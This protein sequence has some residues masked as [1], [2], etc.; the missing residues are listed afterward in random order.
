MPQVV[1][2]LSA[3]QETRVPSLGWEYAPEKGMAT[4]FIF[5][6]P[7]NS[8]DRK[9]WLTTVHGVAKSQSPLNDNIWIPG[10]AK[11]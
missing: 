9:A 3:L 5:S 8:T 7:V 1:M 4:H 11:Y 6:Y 10:F 2:N